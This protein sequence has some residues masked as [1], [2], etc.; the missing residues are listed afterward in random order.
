MPEFDLSSAQ[1]VRPSFDWD[2]AVP[3]SGIN[4]QDPH[5]GMTHTT[6]SRQATRIPDIVNRSSIL[7]GMRDA[8]TAPMDAWQGKMKPTLSADE[9][10]NVY[11]DNPAPAAAMNV[12]GMIMG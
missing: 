1:P 4:A 7:S 9:D 12:A 2:S 5:A 6:S 10:G 11:M 3:V 8:V